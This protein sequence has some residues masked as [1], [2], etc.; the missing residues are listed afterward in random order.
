MP[1]YTEEF[2]FYGDDI[3]IER[4]PADTRFIYAN[5]PMHP[6]EDPYSAITQALD[7]PLSASTL[8]QQ[9]TS[10]SR[11]TIAF[12]DPCLPVPLMRHDVRAAVIEELIRRLYKIGIGRDQIR[13]ICANG[14]HRKWTLKELS[15]VLGRKVIK[16]MGP[17]R[18]SCHDATEDDE[19]VHLGSTPSG[20]EVEINRAAIDSDVTIYV[21]VNFTSMNGGWKSILVGLGSWRSIRHHHTPLQWNAQHSI[22]NPETNPMHIIL[23]EMGKLVKDHCNIF[24]IETVINNKVWPWPIEKILAPI[25]NGAHGAVPTKPMQTVFSLASYAPQPLKRFVRNNLVRSDYRLCGIWA[26]DVEEVHRHTLEMLVRQQNVPVDEQTDILIFG[27]P[28]LSPY[29]ALSVFNP[30]LLRSLTTGY[31]LGLFK[32]RPLVREKGIIIACNPGIEKFHAGHHP[33][34]VDF[35]HSDLENHY[36]PQ[37]CWDELAES[38]ADNPRYKRLYRENFAYHGTHSLINWMWSGMSMKHI[39][40]VIL[41]GAQ[42]PETARKIGFSPAA[43]LSTALAMARDMTGAHA[44]ITYQVIPPLFCV[45]VK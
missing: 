17:E 32:S 35:W 12:D 26:G 6:L 1:D 43:D 10:T 44:T 15:L 9:L 4:F 38:Y 30:I 20:H 13:L 14:L 16:E 24:Q 2:I 41:A 27:I 21:N 37:E 28:N 29:S 5:P 36:D 40:E 42:E 22:M 25:N 7:E 23:R 34:Y 39:R 19:L 3:R 11:V 45:D 31:L 18:I 8:E 33:S